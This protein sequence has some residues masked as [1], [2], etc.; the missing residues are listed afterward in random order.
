MLLKISPRTEE[1]FRSLTDNL[2][3]RFDSSESYSLVL[4]LTHSWKFVT[5]HFPAQP[6]A[7]EE[8]FLL[9]IRKGS[10]Q[11]VRL[12]YDVFRGEIAKEKYASV[13]N[14]VLAEIARG[15][16]ALLDYYFVGLIFSIS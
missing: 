7:P 12:V 5:Q 8:L 1:S 6:K 4:R 2:L 14:L 15:S 3:E 16:S 11:D 10:W 9:L 13:I